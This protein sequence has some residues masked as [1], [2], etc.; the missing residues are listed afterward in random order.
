[1]L[2]V[3][4]VIMIIL[5]VKLINKKKLQKYID[6]ADVLSMY[7]YLEKVLAKSGLQ[8]QNNMDYMEFARVLDESNEVCHRHNI[9]KIMNCVLKNRFAGNQNFSDINIKNENMENIIA[10]KAIIDEI[11]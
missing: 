10:M 7:M 11:K 9:I 8:R 1:M 5:L 3:I 6:N 2:G 4:I